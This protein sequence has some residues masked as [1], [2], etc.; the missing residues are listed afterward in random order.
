MPGPTSGTC[1]GRA[2]EA[3]SFARRGQLVADRIE[4]LPKPVVA[5]V[6]GYALGGGCEIALACDAAR[7]RGRPL[8]PARGEPGHRPRLGR[9]P[10]PG[11][12][13]SVGFAKE[14]ILTGRLVAPTRPPAGLVTHVHPAAD[15]LAGAIEIAAAIA[16]HASWAVASAKRLC[17]GPSAATRLGVLRRRGRCLRARVHHADQREGMAAFAEKPAEVAGW[18]EVAAR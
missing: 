18:E 2:L 10:A 12:T 16:G 14:M 9:D 11:S 4:G 3:R 7:R 17:T 6:N 1:D 15:L 8:R 13:T 5:A